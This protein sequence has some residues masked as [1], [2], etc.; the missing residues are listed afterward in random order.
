MKKI[1]NLAT[2]HPRNDARIFRKE[3]F[4][5]T[6]HYEVHYITCDGKG[7]EVNEGV[8]IHGVEKFKSKILRAMFAPFMVY[9]KAKVVDADI[10]VLHDPELL[11]IALLLQ[12][13][14]KCVIWDCHEYYEE[15]L[16]ETQWFPFFLRKIL[17]YFF[18]RMVHI[19]APH[20]DG[21]ITIS[22]AL[23]E[24]FK[25]LRVKNVF[26]LRNFALL[27][28]FS[29]VKIPDFKHAKHILYAGTPYRSLKNIIQASAL[30]RNDIKL[31]LC[32]KTT[33]PNDC[34]FL[35]NVP[36]FSEVDFRENICIEE[37]R[38]LAEKCFAGMVVYPPRLRDLPNSS[39]KFFEY[40]AEYLPII[41]A[42]SSERVTDQ[43]LL[44]NDGHPL[45]VCVDSNP[46]A[47]ADAI[48]ML[49]ENKELA[50]TMG[51]NGRKAFETKYNFES[52][53]DDFLNFLE[54]VYQSKQSKRSM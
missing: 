29:A 47:I 16:S 53:A 20:L 31:I 21:I 46:Q 39:N 15:G 44:N 36:G 13:R 34:N 14:N 1:C 23:V 35:F 22:N 38:L 2:V 6:R 32:C 52:E 45:G 30:L 19:V 24:N 18:K 4:V 9:R 43:N 49:Y 33:S 3:C 42:W 8:H 40:M 28:E 41:M 25:K 12:R 17:I 27:K 26:L 50:R 51:E 5:E 37:I 11:L 10:Y 54:E 48:D 7:D